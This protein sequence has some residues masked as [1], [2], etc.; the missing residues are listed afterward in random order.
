MKVRDIMKTD[1]YSVKPDDSLTKVAS[2]IC[3]K[4]VSGV[5]VVD[6]SG[7]LVGIISEKDLLKAIYPTYE[8]FWEYPVHQM[9]FEEMEDRV[10][11]MSRRKVEEIMT[12]PVITV[13][14]DTPILKVASLM[15]RRRIRRV[16]VVDGDKLVG[17]V[18]QG[19]IHQAIFQKEC[20][21]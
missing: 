3:G 10:E 19:D 9:D 13:P 2:I 17:I 11:D 1:V 8:E 18:S 12:T 16:P 15:I 6:E 14:S 4:K 21:L 5:S 7:K 20:A